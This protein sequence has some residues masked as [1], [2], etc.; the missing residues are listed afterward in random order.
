MEADRIAWPGMQHDIDIAS[1][2]GSLC[3][4]F[5]P[6]HGSG[7]SIQRERHVS[8]VLRLLWMPAATLRFASCA[9]ESDAR[10]L[11]WRI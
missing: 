9:H 11:I 6:D 5:S 1:V 4:N 8:T 2:S 3:L 10:E 7:V